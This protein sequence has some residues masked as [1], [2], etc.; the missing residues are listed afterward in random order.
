MFK[1]CMGEENDDGEIEYSRKYFNY[2]YR[3]WYMLYIFRYIIYC[4]DIYI[5]FLWVKQFNI[6]VLGTTYL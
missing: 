2:V 6:I 5:N 4:L 3:I 1:D